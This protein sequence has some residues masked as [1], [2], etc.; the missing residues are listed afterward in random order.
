MPSHKVHIDFPGRIIFIGFGSI[1]QGTLPLVLRHIG[2]PKER[3]TIITGD[4]RGRKEAESY[5]VKFV[6]L[7]LTRD[8]FRRE[9]DQYI[10]RGDFVLN[11]SV[12]VSSI[13]L[14]K[15]CWSKGAMY[16]DTCI[17][18]WP[19]ATPTPPFRT[20]S[21]PTTRCAKR[22][23]RC[24]PRCAHAH[25]GAH[26]W[27]QSRHGVASRQAGAAEYSHR[28]RRRCRRTHVARGL[29]SAGAQ[30]RHQGDHIAERDT[31]LTSRPK[32][33]NEFVNTWSVDGFV[34]EVSKPA[35]LG[36]GTHEK[37]FPRDGKRFDFGSGSSI[38]LMQPGAATRVRTWTPK[39]GFFTDF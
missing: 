3:I 19:A 39:A 24:A 26:A 35:E 9:L 34:S 1:G 11:V 4:D 30:T 23:W 13:A 7:P 8:N 31:Q 14:V 20:P 25:R 27:R 2:I 15:F 17:E 22:R 21:A 32:E 33:F 29:G 28:H 36:W 18:P 12:D 38:Y 37:N 16:L 5:G 6:V 10:G